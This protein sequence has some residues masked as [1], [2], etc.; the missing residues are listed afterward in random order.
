MGHTAR[1]YLL[2][3]AGVR[4]NETNLLHQTEPVV[5]ITA[6]GEHNAATV[7]TFGLATRFVP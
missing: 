3:R 5:N 1:R 7:H 4:R 6:I 2:L